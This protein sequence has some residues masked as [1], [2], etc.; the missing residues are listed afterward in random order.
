M[1][2]VQIYHNPRCRKS[3]EGLQFLNDHGIEPEIV[4]YLNNPPTVET[5]KQLA[6]LM[7][8]RPRDFIRRQE[9]DYKALGLKE[10]LDD[11]DTLF[12][13]MA[14]H[15]KLI[16]RPIVIKGDRAVLGRP[17]EEINTLL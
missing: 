2:S 8:K 6:G 5:L 10:H 9:A 12:Q 4:D 14:T 11:D 16:E 15:P 7:G 3:R 13:A 1:A 17:A